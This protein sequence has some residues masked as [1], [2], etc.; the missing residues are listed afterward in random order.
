MPAWKNK[1]ANEL[2]CAID[3]ANNQD[4]T[5]MK[6]EEGSDGE[7]T[8]TNIN[9]IRWDTRTK[10]YFV[11]VTFSDGTVVETPRMQG[12]KTSKLWIAQQCWKTTLRNTILTL[13]NHLQKNNGIKTTTK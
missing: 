7:M 1:Q 9:K 10:Q 12:W 4:K 13:T 5:E 3:N 11:T 2:A 8:I 6:E